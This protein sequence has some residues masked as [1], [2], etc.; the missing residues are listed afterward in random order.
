MPQWFTGEHEQGIST[1]VI[2]VAKPRGALQTDPYP[3]P[4][5]AGR[6]SHANCSPRM[7][8][9][10][11]TFW[12]DEANQYW[13]LVKPDIRPWLR[14]LAISGRSHQDL[15]YPLSEKRRGRHELPSQLF[16]QGIE[17]QP[18]PIIMRA[19]PMRRIRPSTECRVEERWRQIRRS[20]ASHHAL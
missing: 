11:K 1:I 14:A 2:E 13:V 16:A 10:N 5:P 20:N 7:T 18:R 17:N 9:L 15:H 6:E 4:G 12:P 19:T 8:R 3:G